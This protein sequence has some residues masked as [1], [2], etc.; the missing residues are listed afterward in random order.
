MLLV[1]SHEIPPIPPAKDIK[2]TFPEGLVGFTSMRMLNSALSLY[3]G[4]QS[5]ANRLCVDY[6]EV[7]VGIIRA[8]SLALIH[9]TPLPAR[10]LSQ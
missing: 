5:P 2:A 6:S 10:C 8:L 4:E 7:R 1:I 3:S 9:L